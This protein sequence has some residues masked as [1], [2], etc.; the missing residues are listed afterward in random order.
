MRTLGDLADTQR[1]AAI[2]RLI[3]LGRYGDRIGWGYGDFLLEIAA[4]L[5]K[6]QGV[7]RISDSA[8]RSDTALE[9]SASARSRTPRLSAKR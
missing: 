8:T 2:D 3:Q 4:K 7:L 5:Q 1:E 6:R 9:P